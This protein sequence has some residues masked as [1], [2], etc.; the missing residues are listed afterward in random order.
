RWKGRRGGTLRTSS[1][2]RVSSAALVEASIN[3]GK[4]PYG[5]MGPWYRQF[6]AI[7]GT[8]W[9]HSSVSLQLIFV[10]DQFAL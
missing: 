5:P 6:F 4:P 7:L 1:T 9:T 10:V 2:W 8:K 3:D